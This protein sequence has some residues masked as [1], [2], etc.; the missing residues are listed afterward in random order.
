MVN[1]LNNNPNS[2]LPV[3]SLP[4]SLGVTSYAATDTT[5]ATPSPS[6][7]PIYIETT[8]KSK[9]LALGLGLG[10]GLGI[11]LLIAICTII[12]LVSRGRAAQNVNPI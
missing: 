11:P 12:W 10:L 5:P 1:D 4:S 9:Q 3:S 6:P 2:V 7:S 8:D